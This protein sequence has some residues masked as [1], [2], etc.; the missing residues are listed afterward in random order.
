MSLVH[1]CCSYVFAV[2]EQP[3]GGQ[4]VATTAPK[5]RGHFSTTAFAEKLG[6]RPVGCFYYTAAAHKSH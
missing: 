6:L 3:G 1:C 2:F 5:T 4:T